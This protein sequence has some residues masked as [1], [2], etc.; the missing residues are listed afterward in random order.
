LLLRNKIKVF[1]FLLYVFVMLT[2]RFLLV[3]SII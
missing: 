1:L 2:Y 3:H